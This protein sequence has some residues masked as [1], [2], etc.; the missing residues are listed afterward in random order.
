MLAPA[1]DI[2]EY[3]QAYVD[4]LPDSAVKQ[5]MTEEDSEVFITGEGAIPKGYVE[6]D[7]ETTQA[8]SNSMGEAQ[9]NFYKPGNQSLLGGIGTPITPMGQSYYT[10]QAVAVQLAGLNTGR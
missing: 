8:A 7:D 5:L 10:Q 6:N 3:Q 2:P 4:S 9:A 1:E